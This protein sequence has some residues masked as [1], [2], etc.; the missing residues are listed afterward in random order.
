MKE[1]TGT[2]IGALHDG[3]DPF[4][5][6]VE[7]GEDGLD[8]LQSTIQGP[9]DGGGELRV[10]RRVASQGE[11]SIGAACDVLAGNFQSEAGRIGLRI[12]LW[13]VPAGVERFGGPFGDKFLQFVEHPLLKDVDDLLEGE[14]LSGGQLDLVATTL[15]RAGGL[16]GFLPLL[17]IAFIGMKLFEVALEIPGRAL[18]ALTLV[19]LV[20]LAYAAGSDVHFLVCGA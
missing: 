19:A 8:L 1:F 14:S 17:V 12:G 15:N 9:V 16:A 7:S 11:G 5:P 18:G 10:G 20:I 4:R 6:D 13:V 2:G 3:P